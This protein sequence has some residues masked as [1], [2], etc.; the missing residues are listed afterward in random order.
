MVLTRVRIGPGIRSLTA[1]RS[2]T[3]GVMAMTFNCQTVAAKPAP[4]VCTLATRQG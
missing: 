4:A 1:G 2:I 3:A